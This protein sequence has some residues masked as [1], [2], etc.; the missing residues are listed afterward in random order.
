MNFDMITSFT[1]V[2]FLMAIGEYV[3]KKSKAKIPS[4]FVTAVLFL[5]GFWTIFPANIVDISVLGMPFAGLSMLL[6]V[7]HLGTLLNIEEL[8]KQWKTILVSLGGI[9]G[10][11]VFL[12]GVGRLFIDKEYLIISAPPLTGGLVASIIMSDAAK[13]QGLETLS[14]LAILLYVMQGFVGYPI[15]SIV[16]NREA[17]TLVKDFR[18]GKIKLHSE[19]VNTSIIK[20][21][22]LINF[23][24]ELENTAF[25]LCKMGLVALL[26]TLSEKYLG[27]AV[28]KYVFALIYGCIGYEIGFLEEK[29]LNK[30]ES[31]GILMV[32]LMIFIFSSLS[33]ATPELLLS[34][35]GPLMICITLGT[36]G[37]I[38]GSVLVG[39][40]LGFSK[41]MSIAV[42]I[43]AFYGFPANFVLT[44][45]T[46]EAIGETKE[47]QALLLQELM[48]KMIV[49]GFVSVTIVS[50]IVAGIFV[51]LL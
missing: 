26:A 29:I 47:E 15:T 30:Y 8:K 34:I 7:V 31:F 40:Y 16:L 6:L 36:T 24:K 3:S 10:I 41:E 51:N 28:S 17:K 13:S 20:K 50:V 32:S 43:T 19:E 2:L 22:K 23:P 9:V 12:L 14:I 5:I 4:V 35:L 39:R 42:A 49:G 18:N 33:K 37:L 27:G 21:K 45:D 48:P 44:Q 46:C 11:C 1:I 38:I 25:A